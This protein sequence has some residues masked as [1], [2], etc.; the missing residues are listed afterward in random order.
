M[1]GGAEYPLFHQNA[2]GFIKEQAKSPKTGPCQ[3]TLRQRIEALKQAEGMTVSSSIATQGHR[4][5]S[6]KPSDLDEHAFGAF[7]SS[8]RFEAEQENSITGLKKWDMGLRR[9][10][11]LRRNVEYK[12]SE[13]AI[14]IPKIVEQL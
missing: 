7:P 3:P 8:S 2:G 9:M 4:N 5:S 14:H 13:R 1:N 10:T 6:K 12:N 11:S